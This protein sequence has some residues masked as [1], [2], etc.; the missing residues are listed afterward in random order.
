MRKKITILIIALLAVLSFIKV[1]S[2]AAPIDEIQVYAIKVDVN[3]D[4]S[5]TMDYYI[6]WKVLDDQKEG[7]LS[8]VQIGIPNT[9]ASDF[10]ALSDNVVSVSKSTSGSEVFAKVVL[11]REYKAGEVAQ[12]EFS[13]T[14]KNMYLVNKLEEGCATYS[15]TPGWFDDIDVDNL[16]ILWQADDAEYWSPDATI[17]GGYLVWNTSLPAGRKYSVDITYKNDAKGFDLSKTKNIDYGYIIATII[18]V[19]VI[20]GFFAYWIFVAYVI[21][22]A[23]YDSARGFTVEKQI[24][25]EKITYFESCPHCGAPRVDTKTV[26]EF[27]DASMI[28]SKEVIKESEAKKDKEIRKHKKSGVYNYS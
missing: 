22:K 23:I 21:I 2:Y 3:D 11:D 6:E 19:L 18:T 8:W 14:Q 4:A 27:C 5:L 26:C 20:I 1:D 25:R 10:K 17:E 9:S 15:F 13:F 28:K 12:F 24:T 7:P 16:L